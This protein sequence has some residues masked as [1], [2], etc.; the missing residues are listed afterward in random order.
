MAKSSIVDVFGLDGE[1][2]TKLSDAVGGVIPDDMNFR[3]GLM[4]V[5]V[6]LGVYTASD[7]DPE[8]A[9][10]KLVTAVSIASEM[11][12]AAKK[13]GGDEPAAQPAQNL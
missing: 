8:T 4:H 9:V 1:C 5:A 13:A 3:M 12:V 7:S 6:L 10:Q 2:L 11:A